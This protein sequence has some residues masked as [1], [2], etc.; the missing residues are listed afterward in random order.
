MDTPDNYPSAKS[1]S[2]QTLEFLEK[3]EIA[4]TPINFSVI[5]HYLS[6]KNDELNNAIDEYISWNDTI[7]AVY[8]ESLFVDYF[9]NSEQLESTLLTPFENSLSKT[10]AQLKLQVSNDEKNANDFKKVEQVLTK[11]SQA[12]SLKPLV[13][14]MSNT[15]RSTQEQHNKLTEELSTTYKEINKLKSQLKASREEAMRDSLTGLYN[16]RGCDERLK[17]LDLEQVHSSIAIDIDHFKQF[18]DN[19]GHA[20]GDKVIQK[21]ASTIQENISTNDFA[22]RTGG[23]EFMVVFDSKNKHEA[24]VT[25]EKIRESISSLKLRQKKSQEYLPQ[26]SISVGIA[27]YQ[28]DQ[29]WKT[30][31]EMADSALFQAKN[32]GRNC[33]VAV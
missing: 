5:Y 19:F 21:V 1:L 17:D 7:D 8:I 9:S 22:V 23:E 16:R 30:V 28:H 29:S 18:N 14:F 10:I 11:T 12:E 27:E 32:A 2:K 26:I 6:K 13:S 3:Y 33:C 15:L 4:P 31:F 24:K 25:A 20:I